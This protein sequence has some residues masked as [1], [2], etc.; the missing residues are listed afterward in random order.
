MSQVHPN[1]LSLFTNEEL[2]AM[3][4]PPYVPDEGDS[5]HE[6]DP[7]INFVYFSRVKMLKSFGYSIKGM[8]SLAKQYRFSQSAIDVLTSYDDKDLYNRN[9]NSWVEIRK[10]M[11]WSRRQWRIN[12]API[13]RTAFSTARDIASDALVTHV[14]HDSILKHSDL[15]INMNNPND[16]LFTFIKNAKIDPDFKVNEKLVEMKISTNKLSGFSND[17]CSFQI[18]K[19]LVESELTKYKDN[20]DIIFLRIDANNQKF[21]FILYKEFN[22]YGFASFPPERVKSYKNI[23]DFGIQFDEAWKEIEN[24]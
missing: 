14:L 13:Y 22:K 4:I 8:I 3:T 6:V 7:L 19:T 24:I 5:S 10:Y 17:N 11:S 21:A 9:V 15:D 20:E 1:Q 12:G 16:N 18:A 2:E 23:D